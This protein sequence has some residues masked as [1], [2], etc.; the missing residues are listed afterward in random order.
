MQASNKSSHEVEMDAAKI[1][2]DLK[3]RGPLRSEEI[4]RALG[5]S[6]DDVVRAL[7]LALEWK[8]VKKTGAKRATVYK[9]VRQRG[10]KPQLT[11]GDRMRVAAALGK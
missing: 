11:V 9:A 6:R 8:V 4:R 10:P 5:M 7:V 3:E 1:V 2:A